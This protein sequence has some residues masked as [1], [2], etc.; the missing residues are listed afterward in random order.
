MDARGARAECETF[1]FTL[2]RAE[3]TSGDQTCAAHSLYDIE[4]PKRIICG[5]GGLGLRAFQLFIFLA[6]NDRGLRAVDGL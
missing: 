1:C 6:Q 5:F 4:K 2:G 3:R